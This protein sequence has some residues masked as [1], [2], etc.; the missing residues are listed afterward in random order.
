MGYP[1]RRRRLPA[2]VPLT[3]VVTSAPSKSSRQPPRLPAIRRGIRSD[4]HASGNI[5]QPPARN[6][7]RTA[8]LPGLLWPKT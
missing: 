6:F 7:R 8:S 4:P 3:P 1:R 2:G 5:Q